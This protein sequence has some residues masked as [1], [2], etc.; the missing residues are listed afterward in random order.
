MPG[1]TRL[2]GPI[3]TQCRLLIIA[4]TGC[5]GLAG[6]P[7]RAQTE[8]ELDEALAAARGGGSLPVALLLDRSGERPNSPD[9]Q[10]TI[11]PA[12]GC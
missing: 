2:S 3:T 11:T 10:R 6:A 4:A 5:F 12:G 7:N 8:Q 1:S 9:T